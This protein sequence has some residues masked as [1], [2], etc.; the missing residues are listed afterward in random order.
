MVRT[1]L[2]KNYSAEVQN[3][4]WIIATR[5]SGT[6]QHQGNAQGSLA[7][8]SARAKYCRT[9]HRCAAGR[10][11][12]MDVDVDVDRHSST[13]STALAARPVASN[14]RS[15]T[16]RGGISYP[17]GRCAKCLTQE[18]LSTTFS[19]LNVLPHPKTDGRQAH[20]VRPPFLCG[21]GYPSSHN[22]GGKKWAQSQSALS[23]CLSS[24]SSSPA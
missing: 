9:W 22:H 4:G 19:A 24:D 12:I 16:V 18:K 6:P 20:L 2:N 13:G 5:S 21:L 1:L 8:H 17:H 11:S 15:A 14:T 23:L 3:D 7:T 10:V